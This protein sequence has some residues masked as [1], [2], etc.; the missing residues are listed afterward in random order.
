MTDTINKR[1]RADGFI[2]YL[3]SLAAT[4][5]RAALAELR[6]SLG[7]PPGLAAAAYRHVYQFNPSPYDE[8]AYALVAG[9]F[10]LHPQSWQ[11]AEG[12]TSKNNFGASLA[13]LKKRVEENR[14]TEDKGTERRVVALLNSHVDELPEHLRHAVSLCKAHDVPVDWRALLADLRHWSH[15]D[16]YVQRQWARAFWGGNAA[17]D[18]TNHNHNDSQSQNQE[19]TQS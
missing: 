3:E 6:R 16:R 10:A 13:R 2:K 14:R 15:E 5:D 7:Q 18:T 17:A 12:E 4:E 11:P 9:L 1:S 19:E 8:A